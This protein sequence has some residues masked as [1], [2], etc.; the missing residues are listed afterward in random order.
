MI[1]RL[2]NQRSITPTFTRQIEY[3]IKERDRIKSESGESYSTSY[4]AI[5]KGRIETLSGI[6]GKPVTQPSA[7]ASNW[8]NRVI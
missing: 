7:T 6:S 2:F 3:R 4:I 1:T 8:V 5:K